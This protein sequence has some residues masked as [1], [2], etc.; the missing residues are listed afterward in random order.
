MQQAKK[1]YRVMLLGGGNSAGYFA[2]TF[3]EKGGLGGDLCII[4]DEAAVS[5]ERPALTK[6]YLAVQNPARL[7]GFHSCVGGGGARQESGWYAE[8]GITY[9]TGVRVSGVDLSAKECTTEG[10]EKIGFEKLVIATGARPMTLKDFKTPG[11][12]L[13][14]LHYIRDVKD[15][16][17]FLADM[18]ACKEAGKTHAVVIGGGYIGLECACGLLNHG[19][20]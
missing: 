13:K 16:D 11:A 20:K 5:Y 4:T 12:E 9:M 7:P 10:G 3:I 2:R 19:M 17:D 6:P 1:A 15:T 18:A 8:K 14:G